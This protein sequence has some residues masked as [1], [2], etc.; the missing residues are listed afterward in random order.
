MTGKLDK[1]CTGFRCEV[2][3]KCP[4]YAEK[5]ENPFNYISPLSYHDECPHCPPTSGWGVG[6]EGND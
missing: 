3:D 1:V 2:K 5:S 6:A 4:L